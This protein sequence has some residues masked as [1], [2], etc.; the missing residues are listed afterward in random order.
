MAAC[1][2]AV[3]RDATHRFS[4]VPCEA[5]TLI[6]GIGVA[7]DAHAGTLVQHQ[8][9]VRRD[10]TQP[11]LR[12][13]HI[14]HAEL[15]EE[16]RTAGHDVG[17]GSLGENILTDGLDVLAL[18]TDARLLIGET[19][20]RIT[21]LRNPCRQI[22]DFSAGLLQVVVSRIDGAASATEVTLSATGGA[23]SVDG[24]GIVRKAGVMAVVERGGDVRPGMVIEIV[25][26]RDT[27]M[28]PLSPV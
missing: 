4:K 6:E 10:P 22:S 18:P 25:L 27:L 7:G 23:A 28:R 1:V 26:P 5:I 9:R 21:G 12:Q 24:A 15:L 8:S 2:R 17:P 20:L 13:V 3:S 14:L 16:A 11:N 19:V